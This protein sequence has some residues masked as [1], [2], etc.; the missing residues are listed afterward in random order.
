M[1]GGALGAR[2]RLHETIVFTLQNG[3]RRVG[4]RLRLH[5]TIVFTMQNGR[6][7]AGGSP[8]ASQNHS[9]ARERGVL[10]Q[11]AARTDMPEGMLEGDRPR[12]HYPLKAVVDDINQHLDVEGLCKRLPQRL[13]QLVDAKGG[14]LKH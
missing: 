10:D 4:A 9:P 14:R 12:I 8:P 1:G 2:L 7:R 6:R 5:K 3:R 11:V 13:Q